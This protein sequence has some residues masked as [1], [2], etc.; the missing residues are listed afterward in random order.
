MLV[1]S[2]SGAVSLCPLM[3]QPFMQQPLVQQGGVRL[4]D[5]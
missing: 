3:Q 5:S 1:E 2:Q 4:N